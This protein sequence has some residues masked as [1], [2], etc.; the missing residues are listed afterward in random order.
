MQRL[1]LLP[2]A[3]LL[4]GLSSCHRGHRHA[5]PAASPRHVSIEV[6][7]Y[8]PVTNYVWVDVGVRIVESWQEWSDCECESP[9]RDNWFYTD[10]YGVAYFDSVDLADAQVGFAEDT[11][12][13]AV[14]SPDYHE[15][16]A[17]VLI[18]IYA[19]GLGSVFEWVDLS[20]DEPRVY[21][22]VPY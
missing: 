10:D 3:L 20:W 18:E 7:V 2:L 19:P 5:P 6:E 12:N 15:D 14:L 4:L 16:E 17:S 8:D 13:R 9:F 1:I 11:Y 22:P 21:I